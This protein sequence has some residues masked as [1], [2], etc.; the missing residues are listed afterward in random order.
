MPIIAASLVAKVE[1]SGDT[2]TKAKLDSVGKKVDD[3]SK[4]FRDKLGSDLKLGMLAAG[5]AIVGLGVSAVKM[6]G[7]FNAGLTTLVTGAGELPKNLGLVHD[8]M[9]QISTATGTM[10]QDLVAGEYMVNSAGQ[11]GTQALTTLKDAAEGAKVGAASLQDVANGVTT[12]MTD[13]ASAHLTAA[14]ATNTLIAAT[15][16]GKTHLADLANAMAS[17]LPTSAAVGVKLT[18]VAGAMATM[19]AEGT[20]AADAATYLRQMLL[21]LE[22]P[23]AKAVKTFKE[24]GL[25]SAQIA[26][27]M[28]VSLPATLQLITDH[29]AKKF[30]VGSAAYV[31]ALKNMA[32]GQKNFQAWLELTGSHLDVFKA[33]VVDITQKVKAG[34]NSIV[35]WSDVQKDFNFQL[36]QTHAAFDAMLIKVGE[37]LIPMVSQFMKDDVVPAIQHFS[38]WEQQTHGLENAFSLVTGVLGTLIGDTSA[39]IGWFQQGSGPANILAAA[40]KGVGAMI[41]AVKVKDM[42]TDFGTFATKTI[43]ETITKIG[44]LTGLNGFGGIKQAAQDAS[45]AEIGVGTTAKTTMAADVEAGSA[46]AAGGKGLALIGATAKVEQGTLASEAGLMLG[47]LASVVGPLAAV[48]VIMGNIWQKIHPTPVVGGQQM[49][50]LNLPTPL[51]PNGPVLPINPG[52]SKGPPGFASG[53]TNFAGG[54]AYVHQ[55][56]L[57]V[58]MPRGTSVLPA[59][60]TGGGQHVTVQASPVYLDGRQLMN[61]LMPY[62]ADAIRYAVGTRG[63]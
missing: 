46:E 59:S 22:V 20:P 33:N 13:Y 41:L 43:P 45:I 53:V 35:G 42:I 47:D 18:D 57:L 5:A 60:H 15:A 4:G 58:N 52:G 28:K 50:G 14:Q 6:A 61:G 8:Q 49:P 24:I 12:E 29:L 40:I 10:T 7:D 17:V 2:E 62:L 25:T 30:P 44:E 37:Q 54:L 9:L 16:A 48:D 51:G 21:A 27:E 39:L 1:V 55:N 32:G 56:E 11:K 19:T 38:D 26:A 63:L 34:G 3:T 23:G 31:E 36:D